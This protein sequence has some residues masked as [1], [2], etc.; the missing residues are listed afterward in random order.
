M[1][2]SR[3]THALLLA[4]FVGI[5]G[6]L[7]A[8]CSD[9]EYVVA[10]AGAGGAGGV[11][12][13][14]GA[15]GS[16]GGVG[17]GCNAACCPEDCPEPTQ[18]CIARSCTDSG[19]CGT[20]WVP[21]GNPSPWQ[22][23]GDCRSFVCNGEGNAT[24]VPDAGDVLDDGNDCTVDA[25]NGLSP[26]NTSKGVGAS[27]AQDGG[28][29]CNATAECVECL[30]DTQCSTGFCLAGR[31][32][33]LTCEN[34]MLDVG[35]TGVDCGGD[36]G[37]TC[38][39]GEGCQA[40][41]DCVD[42]VCAGSV[43]AAAS[44]NDGVKNGDEADV[45]CGGSCATKC[46]QYQG[47]KVDGDCAGDECSGTMCIPNCQDGVK[48]GAETDVDC[49][50]PG[51]GEC[52]IG[53]EC[54]IAA[55]C[56]S[57][58]CVDG[59]CC[60]MTCDSECLACASARTGVAD[61]TCAP[62][63]QGQDQSCAKPRAMNIQGGGR[64]TCAILDDGRLKCWGNASFGVLG[65]GDQ[66]NH[67]GDNPDEMG[68]FLPAVQLG[69]G[70]TA[71]TVAGTFW[72]STCSVLDNGSI[73]CWGRNV[74]GE[75]GLGDQSNPFIGDDLSEM[76]DNLQPVQLGTGRT[77]S[78]IAGRYHHYCALLT[79]GDVKCWGHNTYGQ[80]GVGDVENRG[81]GP[82]EMGDALVPVNLGTGRKATAIAVGTFHSCAILDDGNVKC[83]GNGAVLGIGET[84][85]RGDNQGEMGD[86]L[87]TVDLGS[88]LTALSIT[89]GSGQ[90]CALLNNGSIKCWG[91]NGGG[92]G[93]GD[94]NGRGDELG[95]MGDALPPVNLGTG[96]SA[97]SISAGG[98]QTCALL[99]DGSVKCWGT[100]S[101][102]ELGLG[103]TSTR[104]DEPGEMGD[105]LPSVDLG[106]GRTAIAVIAMMQHTCAQLDDLSVKC[107]GYNTAGTL[108]LGDLNH[109]GDNPGE[110]G[111]ALPT[112]KLSS[113]VW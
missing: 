83:W 98:G 53:E 11:A 93:L 63:A 75:L 91:G 35:E 5:A 14:G 38:E 24:Q 67:R 86:A 44:C 52:S 22:V 16:G 21:A 43:C 23:E 56:V 2:R 41:G 6:S 77:A 104:G 79:D 100:N 46:G 62:I 61:G 10:G 73:K 108:G 106:S 112:V 34:A 101:F 26:T 19:E 54:Q 12:A 49:G 3:T 90:T 95:E 50:G 36:C 15:G 71:I 17:G 110:M 65:L 85:N 72:N 105:A 37:A 4:A 111:D 82:G 28:L 87:P 96:R 64:H 76:G 89:A 25:C 32:V 69:S 1:M 57:G 9:E 30:G 74:V 33:P 55:D 59:T 18:V 88:G 68:H 47:C 48:N 51:C 20:T 103:D 99:S 102:G 31:C 58:S 97:V 42:K 13:A 109:R 29:H 40:A 7:A 60:N 27:C 81:D 45:D 70:R 107:W 84:D 80:L 94:T 66:W 39:A 78:T 113:N 8:S 92:L